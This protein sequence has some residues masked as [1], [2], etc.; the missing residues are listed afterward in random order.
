MSALLSAIERGILRGVVIMATS[1]AVTWAVDKLWG[2][3]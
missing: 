3:R 1:V 2:Q